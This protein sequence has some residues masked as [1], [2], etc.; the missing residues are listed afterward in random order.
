M[1]EIIF[2]NNMPI[3]SLQNVAKDYLTDG[4]RVRALDG[5]SLDFARGEF[6]ALVGLS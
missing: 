4:Q 5:V 1:K 3:L 6:M 2:P